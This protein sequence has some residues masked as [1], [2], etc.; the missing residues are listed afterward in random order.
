[1][2]TLGFALIIY[3]ALKYIPDEYKT[4]FVASSAVTR[5]IEGVG[6]AI[7]YNTI[8]PLVS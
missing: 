6:G 8:V 4:L 3:G 2:L 5:V 7:A 1:M